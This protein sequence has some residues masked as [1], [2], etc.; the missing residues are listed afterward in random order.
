M[1]YFSNKF[2]K[3]AKYLQY[4]WPEVAWFG[5][6]VIFKLIMMKSN[7]KKQLWRHISDVITI[8]SPKNVTKITSL[9]F[10]FAYPPIKIFDYASDV[11][12]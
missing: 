11:K 3:I 1:H 7:F 5:Q 10:Q 2:S 9:F 6:I 8:T 4:W 12:V